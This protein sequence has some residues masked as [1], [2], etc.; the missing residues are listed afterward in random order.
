MKR[1]GGAAYVICVVSAVIRPKRRGAKP[2]ASV[3]PDMIPAP[4]E[5]VHG[6]ARAF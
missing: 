5:F 6:A 2:A 3:Q 4:L 1:T